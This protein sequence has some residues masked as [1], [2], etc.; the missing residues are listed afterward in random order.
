MGWNREGSVL[1]RRRGHGYR[2][3]L[4]GNWGNLSEVTSQPGDPEMGP[5]VPS[6]GRDWTEG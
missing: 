4:E 6:W 5:L 1:E 2:G 3:A